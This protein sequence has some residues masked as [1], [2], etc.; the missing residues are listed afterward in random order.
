LRL[1]V[2]V[3]YVSGPALTVHAGQPRILLVRANV[4]LFETM[5]KILEAR[6]CAVETATLDAYP[7]QGRSFALIVIETA[8]PQMTGFDLARRILEQD[9]K[10]NFLF[11]H[12]Q[13]SFHALAEEDLLK[14][15]DLLRWPLEPQAL[16]HAV[17]TALAR[18]T[19]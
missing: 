12:T 19:A 15:F 14:R 6:G 7:P 8:L 1:Y 13:G 18:T 17:Q 9:P 3:A 5:R 16:L 4:S 10:A 2:P 11:V